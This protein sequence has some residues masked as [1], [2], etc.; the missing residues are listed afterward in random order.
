MYVYCKMNHDFYFYENA[1]T[2]AFEMSW[3]VNRPQS[4]L[5]LHPHFLKPFLCRID[6]FIADNHHVT[7]NVENTDAQIIMK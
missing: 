4:F 5:I 1:V 6:S 2:I 3:W 7:Q